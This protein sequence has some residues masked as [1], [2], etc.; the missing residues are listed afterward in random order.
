MFSQTSHFKLSLLLQVSILSATVIY[1][2]P[3]G[4]PPENTTSRAEGRSSRRSLLLVL[5]CCVVPRWLTVVIKCHLGYLFPNGNRS[6]RFPKALPGPGRQERGPCREF[7]VAYCYH[8]DHWTTRKHSKVL[9][10]LWETHILNFRWPATLL[11]GRTWNPMSMFRTSYHP[12]LMGWAPRI[13]AFI[14]SSWRNTALCEGRKN[15]APREWEGGS[16]WVE[17]RRKPLL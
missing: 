5:P 14:S 2:P 6:C 13:P 3:R 16:E 12:L 11:S 4:P 9:Y 8:C 7:L 15:T 10:I 17:K 1:L